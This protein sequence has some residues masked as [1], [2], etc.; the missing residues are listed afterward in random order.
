ML[1]R[2]VWPFPTLISLKLTNSQLHYV[3]TS[4]TEYHPD[5]PLN[6]ESIGRSSF[7]PYKFGC[8]CV[9]FYKSL[10][11][12][13]FLFVS[14][15]LNCIQTGQKTVENR[16]RTPLTPINNIRLLLCPFV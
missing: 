8:H 15:L 13:K 12:N 2:K 4:Y 3:Q 6:V 7:A 10:L 11:L 1:V 16:D 9:S 5:W 14:F